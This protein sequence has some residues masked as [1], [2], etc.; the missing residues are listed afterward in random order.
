MSSLPYRRIHLI[1][2]GGA[3]MSALAKILLGKGHEVSGSDLRAGVTIDALADLGANVAIGH[4]P[5]L[6]VASDLVVASSAVPDYDEEMVAAKE[7]GVPTWR[8]PELLDALTRDVVTIGS[9]G[10]HGKTTTAALLVAALR[11]A[12]ADPSFALGGDITELGTNGH[13]GGD[14]LM[15]LEADEAFRTFE[16]INLDGLVVTNVEAE[17]L[18]HFGTEQDLLASFVKVARAVEG[19]VV[20][21]LDDPGSGE[22]AAKCQAMTYGRADAADWRVIDLHSGE[23][24]VSFV[25][26]SGAR[27]IPVSLPQPGSHVALNAAG[28]LALLSEMGHDPE[29]MARGLAAF[30]GVS[31]RWEHR[32]TVGEVT[33][34]DDYAHHPTEVSV[35]LHAAR[36]LAKGRLWAVF[37]PH[38]Y[39]R[40]ER[41]SDEFGHALAM[42]DVVVVTDIYAARETPV[43]GVTGDLV[44]DAARRLGAEV[45]Y[46]PHRADL[47]EFL[48]PRV[49]PGDLVLT[50]GAGDITLLHTELASMLATRS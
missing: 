10:T 1:G 42:A 32:G 35:T 23:H 31:R 18:E 47:A 11:S 43:P 4:H 41:F 8:R 9:S 33:L 3:G 14:Q 29:P 40:T 25:L 34:F 5:E 21:C 45:H 36:Q 46:V 12:G 7:A 37:Q 26:V 38:L 15:V 28:A 20:A 16:S 27:R 50:M 24:G 19:P 48:V 6:A 44:A 13:L 22:V 49:E 17:H 30:R 2:A 39:S